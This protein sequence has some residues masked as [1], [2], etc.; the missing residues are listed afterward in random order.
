[1]EINK[2]WFK[3]DF[4]QKFYLCCEKCKFSIKTFGSLENKSYIAPKI[5]KIEEL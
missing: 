1:M 2:N 3:K 4:E 5:I